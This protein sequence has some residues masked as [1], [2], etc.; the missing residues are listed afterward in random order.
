LA[1]VVFLAAGFLAAAVVF[2]AAGFFAVVLAAPRLVFTAGFLAAVVVFLAAVVV[3]L[4]VA[5]VFLAVAVVF[6]AAG[7]FA[8]AFSVAFSVAFAIVVPPFRGEVPV[9]TVAPVRENV[10]GLFVQRGRPDRVKLVNS[11]DLTSHPARR[12]R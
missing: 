10:A 9:G 2:L 5:V 1:A 4:A 12:P 3:F 8:A 6:L 11:P 7:F